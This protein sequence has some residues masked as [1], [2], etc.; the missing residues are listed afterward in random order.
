MDV[1]L[2]KDLLTFIM[3]TGFHISNVPS[4]MCFSQARR[5]N[6]ALEKILL[7]FKE[8]KQYNNYREIEIS[9]L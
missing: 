3:T 6:I 1:K 7:I 2:R 4:Q 8:L 9:S 5:V